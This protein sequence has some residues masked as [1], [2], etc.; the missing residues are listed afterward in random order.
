PSIV[1]YDFEFVNGQLSYCRHNRKLAGNGLRGD[2]WQSPRSRL[3]ARF[4]GSPSR[5]IAS[6][7]PVIR[8]QSLPHCVRTTGIT[9]P[10]RE[11]ILHHTSGE[12]CTVIGI[13]VTG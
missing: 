13:T 4:V 7:S 2:Q 11:P 5:P 8:A 10:R 3:R 9:V 6:E 1:N 12:D